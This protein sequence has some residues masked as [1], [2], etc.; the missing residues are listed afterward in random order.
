M[1]G[2]TTVMSSTVSVSRMKEQSDLLDCPYCFIP[3][4]RIKSKQPLTKDQTF[5]KCPYSVK[6]KIICIGSLIMEACFVFDAAMI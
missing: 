1:K 4:V 3:L 5:I 6:V 2:T